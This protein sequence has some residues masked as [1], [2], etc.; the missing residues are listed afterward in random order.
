MNCSMRRQI[1]YEALEVDRSEWFSVEFLA[2]LMAL[3][4]NTQLSS[5][6]KDGQT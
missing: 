2:F 5:Q 6:I 3:A 4:M 1:A